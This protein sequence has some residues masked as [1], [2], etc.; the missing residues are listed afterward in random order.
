MPKKFHQWIGELA[1]GFQVFDKFLSKR[2]FFK[3]RPDV[4]Y[5]ALEVWVRECC[6]YLQGL[7][8]Q[9]SSWQFDELIRHELEGVKDKDALM[10]FLFSRMN[11]FNVQLNQSNAV[12]QQMTQ[13][14][15]KQNQAILQLL[16]QLK[17]L[18]DA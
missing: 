3:K 16:A 18:Q 1:A 17:K 2:E 10:A 4:K 7:Y 15:D 9:C 13:L 8:A 5:L 11:V 6:G 14:L 12:I